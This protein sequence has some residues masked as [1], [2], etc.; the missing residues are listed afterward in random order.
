MKKNSTLRFETR[1]LHAGYTPD[2]QNQSRAVPL[3]RTTSYTFRSAEH[4]MNLFSLK[5]PGFIYTRIGNPTQQVLEER[6]AD[7]EGGAAALALASGTNAIFYTIIN[8]CSYGDEV[9]SSINLYGGTF[10]MFNDILKQFNITVRFFNPFDLSSVKEGITEKTRL[11]YT[12]TIG[13]PSLDVADIG[14]L[15]RIAHDNGLPLVVDSTFTT[16]WLMRPIEHGA[17][18]V[19]H[20][21]TKWIGGHGTAIGGIVIDAG[22]FDWK[23]K[24]F[25]LYNEPDQGYHGLRFGHD[26]GEFNPIAFIMRMRMVPL[27]NLGGCISPDNCWLFLQGL[28]TLALRMERH[29]EN[30]L[31]VAKFLQE[32]PGVSRVRYPCLKG[33]P[34]YTVAQKYL[35][36][37]CGGMVVFGIKGGADAGKKFIESLQLVSH[38]AN[39]GDARSL[40]IHPASTTHSQLST[41]NQSDAGITP[42]LVRLSIGIEHIDDIIADIEQ[43][44]NG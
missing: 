1:A 36:R 4:A 23:Q 34:C 44:L 3:H 18:I 28:E 30:A 42:D 5:E 17:D 37:G 19:V 11:I 10:S 27:R 43:A 13:N 40:A 32:H 25:S 8:I 26:L 7:L 38:L 35:P 15:A 16:P 31:A 20:S 24:K 2:D 41:D 14:E 33:D 39:V 21:L 22:A 6:M 9:L 29:S 12:E